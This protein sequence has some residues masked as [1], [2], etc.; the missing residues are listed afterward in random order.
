MNNISLPVSKFV[1]EQLAKRNI[2]NDLE[3]SKYLYPDIRNLHPAKNIDNIVDA[4]KLFDKHLKAK[5][6]III[7]G[8]YD[9]DGVMSNTILY[10]GL[11]PI[12]KEHGVRGLLKLP[13]RVEGYGLN[14]DV[15]KKFV[16]NY[17]PGLVIT[18]DNGIKSVEEIKYLKDC[19]VDVIVL[20]HHAPDMDNLPPA[21]VLIDLHMKGT[22][23]PF[24]ELCGA[25]IAF[26]FVEAYYEFA[27]R[28]FVKYMELLQYAAIATIADVVSLTDENRLIVQLGVRNINSNPALGIKA[29][30]DAFK[31]QGEISSEN[32]N[33]QLAPSI[34]APG[35]ILIPDH[36]FA[37]FKTDNP[38]KAKILADNL[39]LYNNERKEVTKKY[40]DMGLE[41]IEQYP[42]DYVYVVQ[43]DECPEGIVGLV[44]GQIK[45]QKNKPAIVLASHD[46]YYTGSARSIPGYN[47]VEELK[48]FESLMKRFGGHS[49]AAGLS[50]STDNV[51]KLRTG[52]NKKAK[53]ILTEDDFIKKFNV[54]NITL[55]NDLIE[56]YF[57]DLKLLEPFG[58]HNPRPAFKVEFTPKVPKF[59][60][61]G[62][63][64]DIMKDVHLKVYGD[65]FVNAIGFFMGEE[66]ENIKTMDP[67]PMIGELSQNIYNGFRSFQINIL[68][69][70]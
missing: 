44:A 12:M 52:L 43:L 53:E 26:K 49:M 17:K 16:N 54:E 69:I 34:N 51:D 46:G 6:F 10:H 5:S 48:P 41:M 45:E 37:L 24:K 20:D 23:Y 56:T 15:L 22:T 9:V 14:L 2:T 1:K 66:A 32:I 35:R 61:N 31:I 59:K 29:L 39:V 42:D 40:V 38:S 57:E 68:K 11:V 30:I 65:K 67:I 50:I 27:N 7:V 13:N 8:D 25:S 64:V 36:A 63:Y 28:P 70:G 47:I 58:Q 18:V 33:F 62:S 21:D 19:G 4:V 55:T 3:A 60:D